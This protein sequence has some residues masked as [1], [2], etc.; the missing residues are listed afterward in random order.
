MPPGNIHSLSL[1]RRTRR[2]CRPRRRMETSFADLSMQKM[3]AIPG[4]IATAV[5]EKSSRAPTHRGRVP[6][7]AGPTHQATSFDTSRDLA[8]RFRLRIVAAHEYPPASSV[9]DRRHGRGQTH[10]R[11]LYRSFRQMKQAAQGLDTGVLASPIDGW[12]CAIRNS[13]SRRSRALNA[14]SCFS[15]VA[16]CSRTT[17]MKA[18][19]VVGSLMISAIANHPC[20]VAQS[21]S[22]MQSHCHISVTL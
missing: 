11:V 9:A 14:S 18:L 10:G 3:I 20:R 15:N 4:H 19:R 8:Q 2:T 17:S 16:N 13:R 21:P 7:C 12:A 6:Q 22:H 1:R 5:R